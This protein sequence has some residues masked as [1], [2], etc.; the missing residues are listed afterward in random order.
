MYALPLPGE[1]RDGGRKRRTSTL[2]DTLVEKGAVHTEA[3]AWERPKWFSLDGREEELIFRRNNIFDVV[4]E[5]ARACRERVGIIDLSSFAKFDVTGADA[6]AHLNAVTTNKIATRAGGITLTHMLGE[7]GMIRGEATVTRLADDRYYVLTGAAAQHRDLDHLTQNIP[8][9]AD[10]T[11]TDVTDDY[12]ILV[13]AGPKSR[14]TLSGLT[15]ADLTNDGFKWLTGQEISVAG[16]PL[17]ALRVNYVGELGW[18]LH[19]PMDRLV[20]LYHAI[21]A[22]GEAHGIADVG[23]Y[24]VNALRME[25]AYK[26]WGTELTNEITMIEADMERFVKYEKDSFMG[27]AATL[28]RKQDGIALKCVYCELDADDS[29]AHGGEPVLDGDKVIGITTSGGYGYTVGKSLL[30]AYVEPEYAEPGKTFTV[31]ILA[32]A[33]TATVLAGPVWD[34]AAERSRM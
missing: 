11:V 4:G 34:P 6:E 15:E 24:A 23:A 9:G 10:V 14:D 13:V 29:D 3:A 33:R 5:E 16:I 20:E 25:K 18:E 27:K 2:Y 12:G 22:A 30:F 31:D 7:N 1:E 19:C 21:W 28:Q 26:G 17:R 8:D 32:D